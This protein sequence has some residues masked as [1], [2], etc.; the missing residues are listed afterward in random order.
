MPHARAISCSVSAARARGCTWDRFQNIHLGYTN[1]FWIHVK[2]RGF[3]QG[4]ARA[5]T[6]ACRRGL[7]LRGIASWS[8]MDEASAAGDVWVP[9]SSSSLRVFYGPWTSPARFRR[10]CLRLPRRSR[11]FSRPRPRAITHG[12]R[13]SR[14][15]EK[16]QSV[17]RESWRCSRQGGGG[18]GPRGGGYGPVRAAQE[19]E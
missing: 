8:K 14:P 9:M 5:A 2:R 4:L 15:S 17:E 12:Q 19:D 7:S 6:E 13:F 18:G 10:L 3:C 11:C 16:N 1:P